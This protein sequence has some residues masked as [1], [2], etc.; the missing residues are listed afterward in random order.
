MFSS[1]G[2]FKSLPCPLRATAAECSRL[3]CLFSH[4]P[5][6][7]APKYLVPYDVPAAVPA[8][9]PAPA[10]AQPSTSS[11][12]SPAPYSSPSAKRNASLA[13][14]SKLATPSG[15]P[16]KFQRVGPAARSVAVPTASQTASG[17]PILRINAGQ[18]R[19]PVNTRQAM[20]DNLYD[21]FRT[22]YDAILQKQP[23]L[24][25]EHALKQEN[26]IYQRTTKI[27][28]RNAVISSIAT[29]K[30]RPKPTSISHP[31]VGT[32]GDL[33]QRAE[34]TS[35]IAAHRLTASELDPLVLSREEM[36]RWGYITNVPD[37][38]G[39][40]GGSPTANG[41]R[42]KCERCTQIYVVQPVGEDGASATEC[43]YHWGKAYYT[44]VNG[45]RTRIHTCCQR[46]VSDGGGCSRGPHVF[47]ESDAALLHDRHAFTPSASS[48]SSAKGKT[49]QDVVALDCEM[50]YTTGGFRIARVSVVDG[51][52]KEILDVYVKMDEGVDVVDFNT[53]FS[54]LTAEKFAEHAREPLDAVRARLDELVDEHTIIIGHG[55]EN[56]LKA[57]RMVHHRVIDTVALFPHPRGHPYR[58]AL[59][60]LTREHLSRAIQTGGATVG[61]SSVED[62]VA[63]VD[64]VKFFVLNG[65]KKPS[66]SAVTRQDSDGNG[67]QATSG[68][69]KADFNTSQ[70]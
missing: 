34:L 5:N 22:L 31:S 40:G 35:S 58:R 39:V 32:S 33:T 9:R 4:D 54:G 2:R 3:N 14:G 30:A 38:W 24:A 7:T 16:T 61:H 64:L 41:V 57:L 70:D 19:V 8:K 6:V 1:S 44:S 10:P 28:Y 62:A 43:E 17:A 20:V 37:V 23:G 56:D 26:E 66:L 11:V 29:I 50:V 63:A 21:H 25:A 48:A 27:T 52:G 42:M 53:R 51:V 60:E 47:Y 55:L 13:S 59:R 67:C 46:P 12:P 18:S 49:C 65:M 68:G 45:E 69:G 15:P 36:D